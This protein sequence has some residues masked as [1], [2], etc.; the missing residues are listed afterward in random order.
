M[1]SHIVSSLILDYPGHLRL[2]LCNIDP[3][4]NSN[5]FGQCCACPLR[6]S[7]CCWA[8]SEHC[9]DYVNWNTF[10]DL[11]YPLTSNYIW[12][13]GNIIRNGK[14]NVALMVVPAYSTIFFTYMSRE[15][16]DF[17]S[18]IDVLYTV[19]ANC[20]VHCGLQVVFVCLYITL[21]HYHN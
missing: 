21:S 5:K 17:V 6:S 20:R 11:L 16:W 19:Y 13:S 2:S 18:I 7:S 9:T 14:Q 1:V 8:I 15:H 4:N 12:K 3:T 10:S